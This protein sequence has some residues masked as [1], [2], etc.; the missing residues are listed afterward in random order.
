MST[1]AVTSI[2]YLVYTDTQKNMIATKIQIIALFVEERSHLLNNRC[3]LHAILRIPVITVIVS[4]RMPKYTTMSQNTTDS[5]TNCEYAQ[6]KIYKMPIKVYRLTG[7]PTCYV[8][9]ESS[10]HA[11]ILL[12]FLF[13]FSCMLNCLKSI[14][15]YWMFK[16]FRVWLSHCLCVNLFHKEVI[17][18]INMRKWDFSE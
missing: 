10:F 11:S 2:A 8:M 4:N 18:W 7:C 3:N 14:K 13:I 17:M 16:D 1:R 6:L 15:N 12:S 5:C 9:F